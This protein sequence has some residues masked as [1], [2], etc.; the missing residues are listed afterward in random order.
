MVIDKLRIKYN[1]SIDLL[2][3]VG[4]LKYRVSNEKVN[5]LYIDDDF[6]FLFLVLSYYIVLLRFII[7][8][9]HICY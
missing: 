7:R 8:V 9:L 6:N 4:F 1:Y 2:N 5:H 3:R